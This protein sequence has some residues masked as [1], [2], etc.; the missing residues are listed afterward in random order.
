MTAA[1]RPV[2]RVAV[3]PGGGVDDAPA[4]RVDTGNVRGAWLAQ[5][6][7]RGDQELRAQRLTAGKRNPPDLGIVVPPRAFD[8]GVEPHVAAHVVLVGHMLGVALQFGA[9]RIQP[10]PVRV[11]LEPVGIRGRRLIDGKARIAV[12][13]P[14]STQVVLAVDDHDVVVAQAV[15]LDRRADSAETRPHDDRRRTAALP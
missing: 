3:I 11:R 7:G 6:A 1:R 5:E 2:E 4:E 9:R 14:R 10:R 8:G 12:D 13:V 15:E